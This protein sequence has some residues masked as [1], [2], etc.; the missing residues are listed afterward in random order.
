LY[1]RF[2]RRP[3]DFLRYDRGEGLMVNKENP[4]VWG[5][6]REEEQQF[7]WRGFITE[8]LSS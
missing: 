3:V 4:G 5:D 8:N 7:E 1:G 6:D 2:D